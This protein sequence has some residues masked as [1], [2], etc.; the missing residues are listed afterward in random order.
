MCDQSKKRM[1]LKNFSEYLSSPYFITEYCARPSDDEND[2]CCTI[3]MT[4]L[5]CIPKQVTCFPCLVGSLI[6]QC[7]NYVKKTDQNYLC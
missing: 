1:C 4:L 7:L 2:K 6:N 5:C 3:F